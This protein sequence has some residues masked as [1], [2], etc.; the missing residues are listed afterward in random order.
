MFS[1]R[2]VSLLYI[3]GLAVSLTGATSSLSRCLALD[4]TIA[5]FDAQRK[6]SKTSEARSDEEARSYYVTQPHGD[7]IL[8]M[9]NSYEDSARFS[10]EMDRWSLIGILIVGARRPATNA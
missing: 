9:R 3:I 8:E 10:E 1:Q 4:E 7:A 2:F 6:I 5:R